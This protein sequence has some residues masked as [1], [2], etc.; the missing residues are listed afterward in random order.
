[1]GLLQ[2]CLAHEEFQHDLLRW[3]LLRPD[4]GKGKAREAPADTTITL[5]RRFAAPPAPP[6]LAATSVA[7]TVAACPAVPQ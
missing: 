5:Q 2:G 4:K 1:M 7:P 6:V 3:G